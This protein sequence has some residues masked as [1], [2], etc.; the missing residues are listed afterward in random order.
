MKRS[1]RA[2]LVVLVTA[3]ALAIRIGFVATSA[4]DRPLRADAG[5]YARYAHNL[6]EHGTYSL[7]D[8][9]PP[10]PDAFRSPGYPAFVALA[11]LAGGAHWY[12]VVRWLQVALGALLV[13][14]T[15]WLARAALPSGPAL[16]AAVC[17]ALSPHL[18]AATGYVLGEALLAPVLTAAFWLL[19]RACRAPGGG[20]A[21]AAGAAFGCAALVNEA[22]APLPVLLALLAR[23]RLG[24]ARSALLLLAALLPVGAWTAR[25]QCTDLVRTGG[26]RV[27]TSL[28]HGSYPELFFATEEHRGFPYEED[29]EQPEFGS[30]WG[31][32]AEVMAARVAERP[33]RYVSWYLLEKPLWLWRWDLVQG[34]G[35]YVYPVAGS[36]LDEQ[37]VLAALCA[38]M[39]LLH[40]PFVGL[41]LLGAGLALWRGRRGGGDQALLRLPVLALLWCTAVYALFLPDPRY[42]VPLRPLQ[43]VLAAAGLAALL[44]RRG[45]GDAAAD[46]TGELPQW[47]DLPPVEVA[48]PRVPA[49]A[50]VR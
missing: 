44:P 35:F 21:L 42:L 23:R 48:E 38:A 24:A 41:A 34:Q 28:S 16:L 49:G 14:L 4:V 43:A 29:P 50:A 33:G 19:A 1:E 30:S 18:V 2:V 26:E 13:P 27:L 20:A 11:R 3:V 22:L 17:V 15:Y 47:L 12:D 39:R 40:A 25:N 32:F 46:A 37:P 45:R 10:P 5:Q 31:R 9:V 6:V 8:E 7:A 36:I